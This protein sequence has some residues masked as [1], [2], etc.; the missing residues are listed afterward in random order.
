M[1]LLFYEFKTM[2]NIKIFFINFDLNKA[3]N[4]NKVEKINESS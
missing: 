3:I 4:I 1:I 2:I